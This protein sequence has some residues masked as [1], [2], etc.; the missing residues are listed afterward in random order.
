ME[1]GE[2]FVTFSADQPDRAQDLGAILFRGEAAVR[3]L[4]ILSGNNDVLSNFNKIFIIPARWT[5]DQIDWRTI[6]N[7]HGSVNGVRWRTEDILAEG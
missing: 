4:D 7:R 5:R 2:I 6:F 3:I 1:G